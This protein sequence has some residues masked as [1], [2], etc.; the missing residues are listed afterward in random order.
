MVGVARQFIFRPGVYRLAIFIQLVYERVARP[1]HSRAVFFRTLRAEVAD[2]G[3]DGAVD[4]DGAVFGSR[5][6]DLGD[7]PADI[8]FGLL[9]RSATRFSHRS[10]DGN[11][12]DHVDGAR[13]RNFDRLRKNIAAVDVIAL[14]AVVVSFHIDHARAVFDFVDGISTTADAR[15]NFC[16]ARRAVV[17]GIFDAHYVVAR[18][19]APL[20]ARRHKLADV[21]CGVA[22]REC[23]AEECGKIFDWEAMR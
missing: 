20:G 11:R 12:S 2:D 10:T 3:F 9:C 23:G 16:N 7:A 4:F 14:R 13:L 6:S 15:K 1:I 18:R 22:R 17:R 8:F 21:V 19:Q 5:L